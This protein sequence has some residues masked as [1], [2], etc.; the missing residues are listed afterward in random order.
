MKCRAFDSRPV[1]SSSPSIECRF[2]DFDCDYYKRNG[3]GELASRDGVRLYSTPDVLQMLPSCQDWYIAG[4]RRHGIYIVYLFGK[5][6]HQGRLVYCH[7]VTGG[8]TEGG[9]MA[10]QRRFNGSVDFY[11]TWNE[12]KDRFGSGDGEYWLGNEVLHKLPTS[13]GC[14]S[15][16]ML[17]SKTMTTTCRPSDSVDLRSDPNHHNTCST[18][19]Q[20]TQPKNTA[21]LSCLKA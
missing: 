19:N 2:F 13:S 17:S 1:L 8:A 16:F 18:T 11:R 10:F 12:Y 15:I 7:M 21:S 20:C 9:W 5:S 4:F 3:G 6:Q 14:H